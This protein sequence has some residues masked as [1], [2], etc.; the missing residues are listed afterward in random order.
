MKNG[1]LY[2]GKTLDEV[3][4]RSRPL[5]TMW[6]Q[7]FGPDGDVPGLKRTSEGVSLNESLQH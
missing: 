7:R 4:P 2:D 6:W 1:R 5:P 3:Y